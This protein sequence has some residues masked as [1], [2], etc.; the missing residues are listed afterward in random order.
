MKAFDVTIKATLIKTIKAYAG[1]EDEAIEIAH[2]SF[3]LACDGTPERYDQE[4]LNI[5]PLSP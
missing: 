1:S 4:L 5:E 2:E 3:D